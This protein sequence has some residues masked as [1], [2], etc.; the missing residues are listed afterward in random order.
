[1]TEFRKLLVM[2]DISEDITLKNKLTCLM[3]IYAH[4][5]NMCPITMQFMAVSQCK[6]GVVTANV[7]NHQHCVGHF[8]DLSK[9]IQSIT[10]M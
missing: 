10:V 8:T 3:S 2:V 1:M 5:T 9:P 4:M 7:E 6:L